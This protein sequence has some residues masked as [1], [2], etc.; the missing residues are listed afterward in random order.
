QG[1][2]GPNQDRVLRAVAALAN[3]RGGYILFGVGDDPCEIIGLKDDRF[4]NLDP[5]RYSMTFRSAMEPVPKFEVGHIL[6]E[7]KLVG[8]LHIHAQ[9]EGPVIATKDEGSYR[10][11]MIYYRYPGE[12]R[13][14]GGAEFRRILAE[15]ERRV[16]TEAAE[17]ARR[18]IELGDE[19]GI[20]DLG[21]G[22]I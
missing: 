16:R 12:S 10:A 19:A 8:A 1:F 17:V 11:G 7:G 20:I 4:T 5:S 2:H 15:R 6:W 13:A 22:R 14:I 18:T 9:P 21:S 3:N